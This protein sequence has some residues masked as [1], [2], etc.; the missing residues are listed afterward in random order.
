MKKIFATIALLMAIGLPAMSKS[1]TITL[2][3]IETSDVHGSFFPFDFINRKPV[4]GSMARVSSYVKRMRR[5][6]GANVILLDNGD[7]LQ[8]QPTSYYYNYIDTTEANIA[9][10]IVNYMGYDAQVPG[11]HDIEPGHRVYDKWIKEV[12]CPILGANIINTA[13]RTP[14]LKPY[15]IIKRD[16]VKIAVLGMLTPAIPNWL[17][18]N[19]WSG[20]AFDEMVQTAR[21]WMEHIRRHEKPD[22]MIGLF[23]SG[24][25]GGITTA[26]YEE[27]AAL[28]VAREV[29][30][31]DLVLFGHDHTPYATTTTNAA[32]HP[33][34]CLDP[35]NAARRIAEATVT[36]TPAH[37]GYNKEVTGHLVDMR[38]EEIDTEFMI[39]FQEAYNKIEQFV[40]KRIGRFDN[41]ISTRDCYF[42]SSAFNDLVLNLELNITGADIAFN[43][44]L[45]FDASINKG[46]VFVSDMFKLYKYENQ[47]YVMRMTGEE[48]RKHL[49]MSYGLW[50]NTMKTPDDHLLLLSEK[51]IND[52]QRLGF[53]N[54]SFNF[55]SAAGIDYE[56]D[57]TKPCGQKVKILRMSN[58]KPFDPDAWY[59]VAVNSYRGNGGGELLTRGAGIAH[60]SLESRIVWRSEKDQRYY[61]MREIERRGILSPVPNNNWRFVPEDIV[62]QAARRDYDL[63]FSKHQNDEK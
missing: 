43:A 57:V 26:T 3:I 38:D 44:P 13:T 30:G 28:R 39:H 14:Y 35:A 55:D 47:L 33:V 53:K 50:I 12:K 54:F 56:V 31:F 11:N 4:S 17:T 46:D 49:E 18:G 62:R 60:D 8:G 37:G 45:Q 9:A 24:R 19:L 48:V 32:G 21:K 27:D 40:G 61:L 25:E 23:H 51:T 22:V 15:T 58:G 7:I 41:K 6:Y 42:G 34:V 52:Q 36:L 5:Q 20:M 1:K 16:G 59:K 29:E 63:L 2:K 10:S